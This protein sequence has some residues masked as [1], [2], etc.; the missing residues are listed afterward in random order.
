MCRYS[1]SK[2]ADLHV[3]GAETWK[4]VDLTRFGRHVKT[5]GKL[6][7]FRCS[8]TNFTSFLLLLYSEQTGQSHA[9]S[10][11]SIIVIMSKMRE[12]DLTPEMI[13]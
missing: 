3:C 10:K 4:E 12:I 5:L 1:R 13:C 8:L 11:Y 2:V 9:P 6:D 7:Q